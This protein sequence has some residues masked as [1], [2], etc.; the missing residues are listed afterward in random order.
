MMKPLLNSYTY[1]AAAIA[2]GMVICFAAQADVYIYKN[3]WG[4]SLFSDRPLKQAGYRLMEVRSL[5]PKGKLITAN[6]SASGDNPKA[7]K[8]SLY[9]DDISQ[10]ARSYDIDPALVKAVIHAES[11]FNPRAVSRVGAQGL[12]QLMP[13]T[14]AMYQVSNPY[15]PQENIEA[16]C[17]HLQ[18]L[19]GKYNNIDLVLAAYNAGEGTV[20]QYNGIPPYSETRNYVR[21]VK[22]LLASYS[23]HTF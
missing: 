9:D 13:K 21:K 23:K 7:V 10:T 2:L 17:R 18:Y 5:T 4:S 19:I 15:D 6:V 20:A 16:G 8:T 3:E 14:A 11:H 12:M 22:Q 1:K